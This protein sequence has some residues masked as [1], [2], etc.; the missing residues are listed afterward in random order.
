M[1][2]S[3]SHG[4]FYDHRTFLCPQNKHHRGSSE[5]LYSIVFYLQNTSIHSS[6]L[7]KTSCS[8]ASKWSPNKKQVAEMSGRLSFLTM[9]GKRLASPEAKVQTWCCCVTM[10]SS[11]QTCAQT[12]V[13]NAMTGWK[14]DRSKKKKKKLLQR[15]VAKWTRTETGHDSAGWDSFTAAHVLLYDETLSWCRF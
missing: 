12:H 2:E 13:T 4:V 14:W 7:K 11:S 15:P 5:T 8:H 9:A 3:K 10:A 1:G 6:P